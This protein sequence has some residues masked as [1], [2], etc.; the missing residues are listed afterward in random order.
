M[1][2]LYIRILSTLFQTAFLGTF[3]KALEPIVTAMYSL[4]R[5]DRLKL[6]TEIIKVKKG[7]RK[8]YLV[9]FEDKRGILKF[10][11]GRHT[12]EV[13]GNLETES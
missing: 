12:T 11:L 6:K 8:Y 2:N 10:N 7:R 9:F 1:K 5:R 3:R 13:Q 4:A